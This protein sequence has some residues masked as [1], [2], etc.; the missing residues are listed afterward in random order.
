MNSL[1]I[2]RGYGSCIYEHNLEAIFSL[3]M[4]HWVMFVKSMGDIS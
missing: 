3:K 1:F 4:E 2:E